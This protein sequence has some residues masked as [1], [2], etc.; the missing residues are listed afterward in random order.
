LGAQ[1]IPKEIRPSAVP[2]SKIE[3]IK[4]EE[5]WFSLGCSE[6]RVIVG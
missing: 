2:C 1:R 5:G 4:E 6:K 3:A